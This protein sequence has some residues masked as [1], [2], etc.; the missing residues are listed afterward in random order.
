MRNEE[1]ILKIK[2]YV[3]LINKIVDNYDKGNKSKRKPA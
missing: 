1:R 2:S 3:S